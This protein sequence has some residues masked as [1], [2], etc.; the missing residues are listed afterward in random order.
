MKSIHSPIRT[1]QRP[2]RYFSY[3]LFV[4][5]DIWISQLREIHHHCSVSPRRCERVRTQPINDA[6]HQQILHIETLSGHLQRR[7]Q[8]VMIWKARRESRVTLAKLKYQVVLSMLV[9]AICK[10]FF[11]S[12]HLALMTD[13]GS[14]F[15]RMLLLSCRI[16]LEIGII[17]CLT[18]FH[19]LR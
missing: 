1:P 2:Y 14:G 9:D 15:M 7:K 13:V 12:S 6:F 10:Y 4:S 8:R 3:C 5:I 17:T 19:S 11:T 18:P 16:V